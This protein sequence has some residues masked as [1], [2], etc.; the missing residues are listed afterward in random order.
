MV[1]NVEH[2]GRTPAGELRHPA[3]KGWHEDVLHMGRSHTSGRTTSQ[4]ADQTG[5]GALLRLR[6]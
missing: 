3:F 4:E 2:H 5:S 6:Q 1:V